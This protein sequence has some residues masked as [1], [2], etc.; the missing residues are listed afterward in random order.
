MNCN[1]YVCACGDNANTE[2]PDLEGRAF[3]KFVYK[4]SCEQRRAV[5]SSPLTRQTQDAVATKRDIRTLIELLHAIQN[6]GSPGT[7]APKAD[8]DPP[9]Y[10]GRIRCMI[11]HRDVKRLL[12]HVGL[13]S[14]VLNVHLHYFRQGEVRQYTMDLMSRESTT[15]AI[16]LVSTDDAAKFARTKRGGPTIDN[17]RLELTGRPRSPWNK[18]A[19]EVF[20][21]NFA[22]N[23]V[24]CKDMRTIRDVFAT[25]LLTLR[26]QH[27]KLSR[28]PDEEPSQRELDIASANS[29]EQRRRRVSLRFQSHPCY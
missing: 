6:Q 18:K 17:F 16:P 14:S 1:W 21:R 13:E 5:V 10:N 24:S 3:V 29:S 23:D 27:M 25:H 4:R 11:K 28:D 7:S 12:L 9:T 22:Q 26:K 19:G 15:D 20:A 8:G 2:S